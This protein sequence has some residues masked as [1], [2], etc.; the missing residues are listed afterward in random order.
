CLDEHRPWIEQANATDLVRP[1]G[2]LDVFRTGPAFEAAARDAARLAHAFG[3]DVEVL[4]AAALAR[5]EPAL[6]PGLAG[7]VHW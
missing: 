1:I 5:A 2:Y 4:D 3:L 7:A 6:R